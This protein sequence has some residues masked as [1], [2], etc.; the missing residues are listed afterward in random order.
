MES[1]LS[2]GGACPTCTAVV[3][4]IDQ[5]YRSPPETLQLAYV[6]SV[7]TAVRGPC[8][9]G[10]GTGAGEGEQETMR[11]TESATRGETRSVG[12]MWAMWVTT[13]QISTRSI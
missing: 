9:N 5:L 13:S 12:L 10:V 7:Y 6:C 11:K 2:S 8:I 4:F 1:G 3:T